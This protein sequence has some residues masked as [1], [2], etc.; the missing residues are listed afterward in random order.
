MHSPSLPSL[1]LLS[2]FILAVSAVLPTFNIVESIPV[3]VNLTA[4]VYTYDGWMAL[5]ESA[6][7]SILFAEYYWTLTDGEAYPE[8]DGGWEGASVYAAIKTAHNDRGVSIKIVQN[9]P[10]PVSMPDTDSLLLAVEGIA[11]VRNINFTELSPEIASGIL[12][13]KLII[14]D[15]ANF[16]VG[17]ANMDWRSLTQV[18]ELGVVVWNAP[19]LAEDLVKLFGQWW[20]VAEDGYLPVTWPSIADTAFNEETPDIVNF[21][22]EGTSEVYFSLSPPE[23]CT[24]DRVQAATSTVDVINRATKF[25]DIEVMDYMPTSCYMESNF[26]W[27]VIDD[28]L[29][30][31]AYR[32]VQVRLL[33]SQWNHTSASMPQYIT[34]LGSLNNCSVRWFVV[35]DM[36]GVDPVPYTRVNHAKFMVTDED[37]YV[38]NNNWTADYFLTTAGITMVIQNDEIIAQLSAIFERDWNSEYAHDTFTTS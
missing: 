27:P 17:S 5:I 7:E 36:V 19:D 3:Q 15:N 6:Q 8:I 12:H 16:Y 30:N 24:A 33:V 21:A 13:T 11:E 32:G 14:T 37:A 10:D 1:F 38:S 28:A 26:Y 34:S 23:F 25:V 35:P 31:A 20:Q 4:D 18:K 29:R 22:A 9:V 2:L